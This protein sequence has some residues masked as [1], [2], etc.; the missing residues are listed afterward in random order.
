MREEPGRY[1]LVTPARNEEAQIGRTLESIVRQT[2]R[3][4]KYVVVNDNSTDRTGEII[5]EYADRWPFIEP[6]D[7][8]PRPSASFGAK[9]RAFNAGCEKLRG[10]GCDYVGNVDADVSFEP[11]YFERL[12]GLMDAERG[13]GLA[14]GLVHE[15]IRGRLVAQKIS[16]NS[17]CGSV[18]LFRRECLEQLGGY[19]PLERGG[20]DT[21]A[22]IMAR[23]NGWAVRTF[24]G[25][26][27]VANRRV[28]TGRRSV[29]ATR[30][31]KG[32]INYTL[33]YHPLFHLLVGLYRTLH[34]PYVVGGLMV[35]LGFALAPLAGIR[36]QVPQPIADFVRAEQMRRI[37]D[38]LG[39]MIPLQ[40]SFRQR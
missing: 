4:V 27:V 34:A 18:Q 36:R 40:G 16:L 33:G 10:L 11:D 31:N 39:P 20:V 24:A 8:P 29:L 9:A 3:P 17:V 13:L 32:V 6:L 23:M 21:C 28:L 38:A 35:I 26:R 1:A 2:R 14:G 22:E 15:N 7:A 19:Q 25:L 30:F 37:R 12:I 5:R